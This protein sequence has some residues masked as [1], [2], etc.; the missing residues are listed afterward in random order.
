MDEKEDPFKRI[1][2]GLPNRKYFHGGQIVIDNDNEIAYLT[3][4]NL[5]NDIKINENRNVEITFTNYFIYLSHWP[6]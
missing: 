6:C 3:V 4:I 2:D 1:T 5:D